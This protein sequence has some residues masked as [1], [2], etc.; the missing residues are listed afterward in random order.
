MSLT[1]NAQETELDLIGIVNYSYSSGLNESVSPEKSNSTLNRFQKILRRFDCLNIE[2][3]GIERV[4]REDRTD[5]TIINTA[6]MWVRNR[7]V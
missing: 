5:S 4:L 7:I 1:A 6:M 2:Q 3:R